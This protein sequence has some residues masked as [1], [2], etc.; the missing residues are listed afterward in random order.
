MATNKRMKRVVGWKENA[1]LPDLNVKNVIAKVDTGANLASIDASDIKIVSRENVKYVKFKVMKRNNTVRKTS[2]PL[3][4]Y[5][6][7]KSSNGDVERRPYIKTTLL[8]DGISKKIELTLT[9]R[10]PME[11]TMLIGRKALGK[12]WVVNPS[13]S[14]STSTAPKEKRS[15]K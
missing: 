3:E 7:I 13:I 5:K 1:A 4:G 9:D 14:F 10:G 11:Y 8:M 6:R 15:K 2:A 12:R